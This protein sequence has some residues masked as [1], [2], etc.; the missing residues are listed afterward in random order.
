MFFA[1][2]TGSRTP[3][4]DGREDHEAPTS[5]RLQPANI[6]HLPVRTQRA[7][8]KTTRRRG[9]QKNLQH[10]ISFDDFIVRSLKLKQSLIFNGSAKFNNFY[11]FGKLMSSRNFWYDLF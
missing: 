10:F 7:N 1:L 11:I 2:T 5:A 6:P 9:P 8:Q 3:A 4:R